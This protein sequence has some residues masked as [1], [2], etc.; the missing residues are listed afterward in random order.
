MVS[1]R[2]RSVLKLN[3]VVLKR[4]IFFYSIFCVN[5]YRDVDVYVHPIS[6]QGKFKMNAK[7]KQFALSYIKQAFSCQILF[8]PN[9]FLL[10]VT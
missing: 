2:I 6:N 9:L 5:R 1:F 4:Y 3:S 10:E 8:F 7:P